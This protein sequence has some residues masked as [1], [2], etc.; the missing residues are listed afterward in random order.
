MQCWRCKHAYSAVVIGVLRRSIT[1]GGH[2]KW[3][4]SY[5]DGLGAAVISAR[6]GGR[7]HPVSSEIIHDTGERRVSTLRYRD[8]LQRLIK[9]RLSARHCNTRRT[10]IRAFSPARSRQFTSRDNVNMPGSRYFTRV[11]TRG[12]YFIG[13]LMPGHVPSPQLSICDFGSFRAAASEADNFWTIA[14]LAFGL[15][16]LSL[17]R[18]GGDNA[19]SGAFVCR[20]VI[21]WWLCFMGLDNWL[22][23]W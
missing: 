17:F 21:W 23:V 16:L 6:G 18:E 22:L 2:V 14:V 10:W 7:T 15:F 9:V 1:A 11:F 19:L 13:H 8:V 20:W 5:P 12:L 4:D 3:Q